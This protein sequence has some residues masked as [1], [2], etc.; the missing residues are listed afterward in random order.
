MRKTLCPDGSGLNSRGLSRRGLMITGLCLLVSAPHAPV[1]AFS[2]EE[3]NRRLQRR[4]PD[5]GRCG[6]AMRRRLATLPGDVRIRPDM[7]RLLDA[8]ASRARK[9]A[10][11]APLRPSAAARLAAR[12]QAADMLLGGYVGHHS[13]YGCDFAARFFAA[14]GPGHG[15]HGENAARDTRPGPVDAAKARRLFAQWLKSPGH[16]RNLM[17][18][19]WRYVATGAVARGH[20][21]YAV[22]IYWQK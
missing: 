14:A 13:S 4:A 19:G 22:Q 20:H 16:R 3:L 9:R 2:L 15:S 1:M 6:R 21:L 8:M 7:E 5:G 17:R 10:G 12:A 18:P 11:L